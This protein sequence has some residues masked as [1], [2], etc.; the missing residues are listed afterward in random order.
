MQIFGH[1]I[2]LV[3]FYNLRRSF[4]LFARSRAMLLLMLLLDANSLAAPHASISY[5]PCSPSLA[6]P[7]L[8][9]A[10]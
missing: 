7:L 3:D 1:D 8:P 2:I 9:P 4:V 5:R 10:R 6:R